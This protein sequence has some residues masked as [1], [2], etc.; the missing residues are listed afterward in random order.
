VGTA[1]PE[2]TSGTDRMQSEE[3]DEPA[4]SRLP[5]IPST[6]SDGEEIPFVADTGTDGNR[7]IP[8]SETGKDDDSGNESVSGDDSAA[9]DESQTA[10]E[11][12]RREPP[13]DTDTD[14][15]DG[16]YTGKLQSGTPVR[17][18]IAGDRVRFEIEGMTLTGAVDEKGHLTAEWKGEVGEIENPNPGNLNKEKLI[19]HFYID[20]DIS[21]TLVLGCLSVSIGC[22]AVD[23]TPQVT[24]E[25]WSCSR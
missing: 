11:S 14:G 19:G 3:H 20:G 16:V 25:S 1:V 7:R 9:A 15:F 4:E 21:G 22:P 13:W 17:L 23:E 12:D 10:G 18:S 5:E 24:R 2:P 6:D 8:G